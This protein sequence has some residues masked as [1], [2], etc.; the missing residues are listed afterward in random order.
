M[1]YS[2]TYF[3]LDSEEATHSY[4]LSPIVTLSVVCTLKG[5]CQHTLFDLGGVEILK[6]KRSKQCRRCRR[7]STDFKALNAM[8]V[9]DIEDGVCSFYA[10][11]HTE[12]CYSSHS[13]QRRRR[14][15]ILLYS[16][17]RAPCPSREE[18]YSIYLSLLP[19]GFSGSPP[20]SP[21]RQLCLKMFLD[22][23]N[24]KGDCRQDAQPIPNS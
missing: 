16:V 21:R 15:Q 17:Y 14:C 8:Y 12:Y 22:L 9:E 7:Y 20:C 6:Y 2:E 18:G 3:E 19:C 13:C 23:S 4:P 24:Y 5:M 11:L 10:T 1:N